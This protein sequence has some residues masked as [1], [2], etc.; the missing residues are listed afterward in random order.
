M[1]TR[2]VILRLE[3]ISNADAETTHERICAA[4]SDIREVTDVSYVMVLPPLGLKPEANFE[5]IFP[6]LA[7]RT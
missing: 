6:N 7:S 3:T 4:V 5:H 1:K 2:F